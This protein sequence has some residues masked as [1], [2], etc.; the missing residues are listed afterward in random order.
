MPWVRVR[1]C[2]QSSR[3]LWVNVRKDCVLEKTKT[4]LACGLGRWP[5]SPRPG[6]RNPSLPQDLPSCLPGR[7]EPGRG[8]SQG[9]GRPASRVS[10]AWDAWALA[11]YLQPRLRVSAVRAA[12]AAAGAEGA[13]PGA[14]WPCVRGSSPCA[15]FTVGAPR[16]GGDRLFFLPVFKIVHLNNKCTVLTI[17]MRPV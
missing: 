6:Q 15:H 8:L 3:S 12:K 7:A 16:G 9:P 1:V 2:A 11:T 13:P 14:F 5:G 4:K 10:R 17:F